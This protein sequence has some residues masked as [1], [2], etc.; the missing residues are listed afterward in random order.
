MDF[1]EEKEQEKNKFKQFHRNIL[2]LLYTYIWQKW[3]DGP[4][5]LK[6]FNEDPEQKSDPDSDLNGM[7][8]RNTADNIE[9][10]EENSGKSWQYSS[11]SLYYLNG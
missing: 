2:K 3:V 7:R 1:S 11:L 6:I 5:V 8:I 9:M 10:C 4:S